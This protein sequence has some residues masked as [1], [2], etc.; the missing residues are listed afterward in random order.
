MNRRDVQKNYDTAAGY[1]DWLT[2]SVFEGLLGLAKYR[3][4][5]IDRLD[6]IEGAT[7]LDLGC[8]TG[9][10]FPLLQK[11]VGR[12]GRIIGVDYSMG[13][14]TKARKRIREEKWTNIDL[15]RDD[16]VKLGTLLEPVDAVTAAWS[17]GIVY[18]LSTALKRALEMLRPGGY[19]SIMDFCRSRPEHGWLKWL[20]PIYRFILRRTGIDTAEDLN[21]ALLRSKWRRGLRIL[22]EGLERVQIAH[23]LFGAGL[24]VA[25]RKPN[26][27][28]G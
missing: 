22:D 28:G 12:K 6:D 15:V 9:R 23:Y 19:L 24:I 10:N 21:D 27:A 17:L 18:D 25:G 13:M 20:F 1:Y 4:Q 26:R 11:R 14:L 7:V 5:A 2:G 16:V 8:G 3:R